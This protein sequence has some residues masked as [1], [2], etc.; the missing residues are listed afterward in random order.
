MIFKDFLD[1]NKLT[2]VEK[3]VVQ[4]IYSNPWEILKMTI[5]ELAEKSFT[6]RSTVVRTLHKIGIDGYKGLKQVILKNF[7]ESLVGE[8]TKSNNSELVFQII[9]S[10]KEIIAILPEWL[11]IIKKAKCVHV[12]CGLGIKPI[13]E[14]FSN[15][16]NRLGIK[17]NHYLHE[18]PEVNSIQEGVV[19]FLSNSGLNPNIY[20]KAMFLH[21]N[22]KHLPIVSIT[23]SSVSNIRNI[24]T[25][26]VAGSGQIFAHWEYHLPFNAS[27]ILL[28]ICN[29]L[30]KSLFI[31]DTKKYNAFLD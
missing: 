26:S 12:I 18:Q 16:L 11:E 19:I 30:I 24:A 31:S 29:Q 3:I 7:D 17:A 1:N 27:V 10:E 13:G 14:M 28:M 25:L 21:K 2:D 23:S 22:K 5:D 8:I 9:N 6:T 4:V 15:M 20:Q